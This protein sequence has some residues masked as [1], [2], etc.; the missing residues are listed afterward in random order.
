MA[1]SL[2]RTK[3]KLMVWG[4]IR[5][6]ERLINKMM[7]IPNEIYDMIFL[8]QQYADQWSKEHKTMFAQIMD[9][10]K[11]TLSMSYHP[12]AF[13]LGERVVD[14][15]I[16]RWRLKML[17][18]RYASSP[19]GHPEIGIIEDIK[20]YTS[21]LKGNGYWHNIGYQFSGGN[22]MV[23]SGLEFETSNNKGYLYKYLWK[24]DDILEIVL[25][26]DERTLKLKIND[27]EYRVAFTGIEKRKYRLAL[28]CRNAYG[29]FVLL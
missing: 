12:Q 27:G 22:G 3:E 23:Y 29:E 18:I 10:T 4:Y 9:E 28:S 21:I 16:F 17:C 2:S 5:N 15:G 14:E 8:Y 20:D 19:T 24:V 13:V 25:D 11:V 26:L 6:I 7:N 1:W